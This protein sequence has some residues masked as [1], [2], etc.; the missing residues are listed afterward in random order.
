MDLITVGRLFKQKIDT[1]SD[2]ID[3]S[4]GAVWIDGLW[5]NPPKKEIK[6]KKKLN[7]HQIAAISCSGWQKVYDSILVQ[8]YSM[9]NFTLSVWVDKKSRQVTN[10][11][12]EGRDVE[13]AIPGAVP[14]W[15]YSENKRDVLENLTFE[16]FIN[17]A[18]E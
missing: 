15:G 2:Y 13:N 5:S 11:L 17:K 6:I 4:T 18:E 1:I 16:D 14:G 10:I 9:E 12:Y 3:F 7:P 8:F